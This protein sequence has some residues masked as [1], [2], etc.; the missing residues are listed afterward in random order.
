[1]YVV[2]N[3]YTLPFKTN[4]WLSSFV[5]VA[6]SIGLLHLALSREQSGRRDNLTLRLSDSVMSTVAVVCQMEL[7]PKTSV[8]STRIIMVSF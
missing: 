3:I 6:I 7:T 5:L 4:V 8:T 2:S 1:M